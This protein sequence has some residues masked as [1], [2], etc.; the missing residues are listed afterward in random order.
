MRPEIKLSYQG[1]QLSQELKHSKRIVIK[2]RCK[3]GTYFIHV[4]KWYRQV[5][6]M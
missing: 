1:S 3:I 5:L 2:K 6:C 4:E